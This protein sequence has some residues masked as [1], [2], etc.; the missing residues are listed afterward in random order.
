MYVNPNDLSSLEEELESAQ[1]ESADAASSAESA[2]DAVD[3]AL[4]TLRDIM[5]AEEGVDIESATTILTGMLRKLASLEESV[6]ELRTDI[7][8]ALNALG[9]DD[10]A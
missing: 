3:N 6:Y 4:E 8:G 7:N 2:K 9:E 10:D 1:Y 5:Q